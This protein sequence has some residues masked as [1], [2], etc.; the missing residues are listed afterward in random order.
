MSESQTMHRANCSLSLR[1]GEWVEVRTAEEILATL[2]GRQSIDGLPFMPEMLQHCGKKFR[3]SAS[4]HKTADTI[5]LFSIRRLANAVHLEDLRCDGAAHGGCQAG[6]LLFWKEPWIKRVSPESVGRGNPDA[7]SAPPAA[8]GRSAVPS[9]LLDRGT[10]QPV[11]PEEGERYRCQATEMIKATSEVRGRDRLN[12]LFYVRDLTSG[13]V[14][15]F[16]F[17]R[18]G[19]LAFLNGF[20]Q[21]W[22]GDLCPRLHPRLHGLAGDKTPSH[23]L[24]L[25]AGEL[26]RVKSKAEIQRTL[27]RQLRNRGLNFD[28]EMVPYCGKGPFKV[29]CPVKKLI[30]EKTGELVNLKNPCIILEGVTCS[31]N[32]L[33][34]RMFSPRREYMFFREIWLERFSEGN[35]QADRR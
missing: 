22:F 1:V 6:C 2:D 18:F 17:I 8:S 14:S 32:Y 24:N 25:R 23:E 16:D 21:R 26:V 15:L 3:V 28:Y 34:Q 4:A 10:R 5:E 27:N 31:G 20:F 12:P 9:T 7:V 19:T 35:Q 13:N 33:T 11:A 30:N 29:L